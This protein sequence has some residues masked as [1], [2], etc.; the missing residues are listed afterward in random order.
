[1]LNKKIKFS[2]KKKKEEILSY[3]ID[4]VNVLRMACSI[5]NLFLKLVNIDAFREAITI[6]SVCNKVYRMIFLKAVGLIPRGSHRMGDRQSTEA[7][8]WLRYMGRTKNTVHAGVG[9][10]VHLAG[11]PNGKVHVF[12]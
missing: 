7:L 8:Q 1:M 4:D 3:C 9:R 2:K 10:E 11:V 6:S 12:Y 5:R